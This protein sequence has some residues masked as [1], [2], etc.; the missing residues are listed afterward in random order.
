[1][2]LASHLGSIRSPRDGV[3]SLEVSKELG[4]LDSNLV[5]GGNSESLSNVFKQKKVQSIYLKCL[6]TNTKNMGNQQ[7]DLVV[8][9][10]WRNYDEIRIMEM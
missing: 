6:Y 1:M 5:G 2:A 9:V 10:Q 7:K 8:L 4:D 3:R